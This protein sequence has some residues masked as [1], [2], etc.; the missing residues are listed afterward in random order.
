MWSLLNTKPESILIMWFSL[1]FWCQSF[2]PERRGF[3]L[4]SFTVTHTGGQ[5]WASARSVSR[6]E[7]SASL[8]IF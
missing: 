1:F 4:V 2:V 8:F 5:L 7:T 3:D 6:P